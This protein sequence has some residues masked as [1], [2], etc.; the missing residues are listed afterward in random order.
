[1]STLLKVQNRNALGAFVG[2]GLAAVMVAAFMWF[3]SR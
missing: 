3:T 1:M 2:L